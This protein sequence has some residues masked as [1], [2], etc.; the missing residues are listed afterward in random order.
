MTPLNPV[1][2][3]LVIKKKISISGGGWAHVNQHGWRGKDVAGWG[4]SAGFD[5]QVSDVT[6]DSF[7]G[8]I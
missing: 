8:Q 7:R 3:H 2:K 1:P 4:G 6:A 5:Q